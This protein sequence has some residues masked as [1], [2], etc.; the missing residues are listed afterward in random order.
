MKLSGSLV[1]RIAALVLFAVTTPWLTF[2]V[3]DVFPSPDENANA[4]FAQTIA[5]GSTLC[6]HDDQAAL[7]GGLVHPR[8]T[9]VVGDCV[10]PGS[11]LG[12]PVL[13]GMMQTWFGVWGARLLTPFLAVIAVMVFWD[14]LRRFTRDE[15]V[16]DLSSVFLMSAPPFWY[17]TARVMM[18]NVAFVSLLLLSVWI[19]VVARKH[20]RSMGMF[21]SGLAAGLAIIVRAFEAPWILVLVLIMFF[22]TQTYKQTRYVAAWILGCLLPVVF[23]GMVQWGTYGH[24]LSTGYTVKTEVA[25]VAASPV[26]AV[27]QE[28]MWYEMF[29]PFGFDFKG[30]FRNAYYYGF[31]LY[32]WIAIPAVAGIGIALRRRDGWRLLAWLG[33][34]L[35]VWLVVVYGSWTF[36]DN[37]D[38]RAITIGNS[39][40]RYWLPLFVLGSVFS[41]LAFRMLFGA[42]AK[43]HLRLAQGALACSV[44]VSVGLS[45]SLVFAGKDGLL[46]NR[47]AM[48]TFAIKRDAILAATE[49]HA[50][51]VV[52]RADKYLFPYRSVV[53][54]LRSESTY[55]AMPEL[56]QAGPLYYFG[57]TFPEVDMNYLNNEK[58]F[59]LGLHIDLVTT[60]NEE[61]LYRITGL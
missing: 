7:A 18:H 31:L 28:E 5:S 14:L 11:F 3:S 12:F 57:V 33:V 4:Q 52:D 51:I 37:P 56:A 32:P 9:A 47:E 25:D 39:H 16:A 34:A 8:S 26:A 30:I 21:F 29:L 43:H 59:G 53:V 19:F 58:L 22:A 17:Y 24:P 55:L 20:E 40:V 61:S 36:A 54:P 50:V 27:V 60:V 10:V 35:G 13:A 6:I 48:S 38:P 46:A 23:M 41:G 49:E 2:G 45:A 42:L 15:F 44:L 1:V